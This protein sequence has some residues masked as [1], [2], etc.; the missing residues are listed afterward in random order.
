ML[1]AIQD[2]QVERIGHGYHVV[3]DSTVYDLALSTKT[4]FEVCPLSSYLTSAVLA[5][6][7]EHPAKR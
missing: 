6:W 2:L 4:H 7:N 5:P 1:Q 3:D